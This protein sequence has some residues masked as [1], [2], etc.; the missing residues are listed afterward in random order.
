MIYHI[1]SV[2]VIPR[3]G[4]PEH[5]DG[6]YSAVLQP[7]ARFCG[8]LSK[9]ELMELYVQYTTPGYNSGMSPVVHLYDWFPENKE[10]LFGV[11]IRSS[12]HSL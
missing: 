11:W 9:M 12:I 10:H 6:R 1:S 3:D 7:E 5:S 2:Q 4:H 8:R